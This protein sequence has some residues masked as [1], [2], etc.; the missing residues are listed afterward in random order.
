VRAAKCVGR[1]TFREMWGWDGEVREGASRSNDG[2]EV[3]HL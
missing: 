2:S 3:V 1:R